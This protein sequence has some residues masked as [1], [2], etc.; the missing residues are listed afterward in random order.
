VAKLAIIHKENLAKFG[1][2]SGMKVE[3][4][5]NPFHIFGYRL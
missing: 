1:Y 2:K 4:F 3:K 5:K